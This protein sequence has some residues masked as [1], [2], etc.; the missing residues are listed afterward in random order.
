[1]AYHPTRLLSTLRDG[2]GSLTVSRQGTSMS[3][4]KTAPAPVMPLFFNRVVGINPALHGGLKLDRSV[5]YKFAAQT[6]AVPLG[7][8]EMDAA[9][10]FYPIL[11]TTGPAPIPVALLGLREGNNLFVMPDGSWRPECYVPAYVRAFPFIFV[12]DTGRNTTF[13]GIEP[14]AASLRQDSGMALFEDGQPSR[15]LT[16]QVNFSSSLRDN[17]V[18]AGLFGRALEAAGL[19]SEE[20]ANIT[21]TAGGNARIRG[22]KLML[23][24][25]IEQADDATFLDWRRRGW[26]SAVY[27]HVHSAG[28]WARLIDLAANKTGT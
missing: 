26:I 21:F 7:L 3:E 28:R 1:M 8:G 9:A 15:A 25:K 20:E 17:L 22:F 12:E 4:T 18:A 19:L 14:D 5:G 6:Q 11:F 24:E 27:A 23:P 16:E 10:Q 13:V 2:W